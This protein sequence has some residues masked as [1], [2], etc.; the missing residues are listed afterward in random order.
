MMNENMKKC[1][2]YLEN[3]IKENPEHFE[4]PIRNIK[5]YAT[6]QIVKD[7]ARK[8]AHQPVVEETYFERQCKE[9]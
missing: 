8:Q 1:L 6:E 3:E 9:Y 7:E 5:S 4:N 2:S